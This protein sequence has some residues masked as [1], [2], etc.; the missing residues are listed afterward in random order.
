[1]R[2][3]WPLADR[4]RKEFGKTAEAPS[5]YRPIVRKRAVQPATDPTPSFA[6]AWERWLAYRSV[7]QRPLRLSTLAD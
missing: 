3:P 7:S 1:M 6:Q 2:I 4:P 5:A